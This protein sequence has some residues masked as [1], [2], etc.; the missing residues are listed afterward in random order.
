MA[1]AGKRLL[2]K[3]EGGMHVHKIGWLGTRTDRP[4]EMAD[5]FARVL[6]IRLSHQEEGFWVF[7]LPDGSKV[8]VFGPRSDNPHFTTGPV[9][10]FLVE[11]VDAATEELRSSGIPLV[12]GPIRFD[13]DE[14]A[15]VHFRAPD[16]NIYEI[17]Q[18]RDLVLLR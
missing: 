18:G 9:P 5:L 14:V 11:D 13:E 12:S 10:G 6:G 3:R 17:T 16:G 4:E 8:E 1:P 2:L 7:Q 15:W